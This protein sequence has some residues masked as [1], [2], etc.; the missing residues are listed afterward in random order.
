VRTALVGLGVLM[1]VGAALS[2]SALASSPGP[3]PFI[4][5]AAGDQTP[6]LGRTTS[7]DPTPGA[8]SLD[9]RSADITADDKSL[10]VVIRVTNLRDVDP[11]YTGHVYNFY[12]R[13]EAGQ[14]ALTANLAA[15]GDKFTIA[16]GPVA[17]GDDAPAMT[18]LGEIKGVVDTGR[19][20]IR[21][22]VPR[23]L[24]SRN[25]AVGG[26][27]A[28]KVYAGREVQTNRVNG[29]VIYAEHIGVLNNED[30]ASTT[31]AYRVGKRGCVPVM[32]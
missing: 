28:L 9:L 22:S 30:E 14:F 10:S 6:V 15:D 27:S 17:T 31:H 12:F 32:H 2:G 13:A 21:M 11:V 16:S 18:G 24:L 25:G 19:H 5:D 7:P 20:E 8:T 29:P 26:V 23:T 3:C 4:T 1:S